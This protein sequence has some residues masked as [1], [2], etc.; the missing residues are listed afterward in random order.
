MIEKFKTWFVENNFPPQGVQIHNILL[1]EKRQYDSI[2]VEY[3]NLSCFHCLN[4]N[5]E[6]ELKFQASVIACSFSKWMNDCRNEHVLRMKSSLLATLIFLDSCKAVY[7]VIWITD[8]HLCNCLSGIFSA[9]WINNTVSLESIDLRE[10]NQYVSG[11][12]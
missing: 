5:I 9:L 4:T 10:K 2:W 7:N 8:L 12:W 11:M 3:E 1:R 6:N